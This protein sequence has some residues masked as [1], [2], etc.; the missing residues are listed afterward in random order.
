MTMEKLLSICMMIVM[1]TSCVKHPTIILKVS[2]EESTAIPYQMGQNVKFVDQNG[3]TLTYKVTRDIT[4]PYS[5]EQSYYAIHGE[6]LFQPSCYSCYARSVVLTCNR[7]N[8]LLAITLIP[9]KEFLFSIENEGSYF[10]LGGHFSF[11]GSCTING[12]NYENVQHEIL[13]DQETDELLY[14]WCYNEAFG[15]LY[16]RKGDFELTRIP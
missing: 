16:F 1:A 8:K 3:D 11:N 10:D 14:D 13:R 12:I 15:L 9:R 2:D 5:G 6:E 4:Y 7:G